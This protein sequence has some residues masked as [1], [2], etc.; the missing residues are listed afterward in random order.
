[1]PKRKRTTITSNAV[2]KKDDSVINSEEEVQYWLFKSEPNVFGYHHLLME[3]EQT[4]CW[5]GV[6]NYQVCVIRQ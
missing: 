2:E 4:A 3:P 1:M 6:R 5:D